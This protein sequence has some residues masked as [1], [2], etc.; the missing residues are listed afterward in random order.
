MPEDLLSKIRNKCAELR[1]AKLQLEDIEDRAT[2]LQQQIKEITRGELPD[3]MGQA[4]VPKLHISAEGNLP[5]F[6]I[7]VQPFAR[8]NIPQ[9]W[10]Q[11]QRQ[12]AFDW[13]DEH[14]HGDLIKTEVIVT[15]NRDERAQA[16]DLV[17][18]LRSMGIDPYI[19]EAVHHATMG[20]WL[21]ECIARG[22]V[23]PLDIV[24]G[25]VGTEAVIK[26]VER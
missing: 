19:T 4:G 13:L 14:G 10:P 5:A 16:L 8:A 2:A 3:L 23:V 6:E 18:R 26:E 12:Q 9:G 21:R 22:V 25:D 20:K 24:G 15:F 1:D 11:Q 17:Q 7:K